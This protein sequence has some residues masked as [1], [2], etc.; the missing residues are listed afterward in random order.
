MTHYIG[1]APKEKKKRRPRP[2]T[3]L[4]ELAKKH[5]P[6][7]RDWIKA[8]HPRGTEIT[9]AYIRDESA[10]LRDRAWTTREALS[11]CVCRILL[12]EK[13]LFKL[14]PGSYRVMFAL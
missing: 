12:D 14:R 11:F 7:I 1:P 13:V 4:M 6:E 10:P 8:T 9:R 5:V 2:G 3:P